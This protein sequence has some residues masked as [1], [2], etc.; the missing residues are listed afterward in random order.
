MPA[1]G[2]NM[3]KKLL[4]FMLLIFYSHGH[5][6][7][8]QN[9]ILPPFDK[10][11]YAAA[12]YKKA[13]DQI[14]K[15]KNE[16]IFIHQVTNRY[17]N[18]INEWPWDKTPKIPK[19]I[20]QIWV[21]PAPLPATFAAWQKT[22]LERHPDWDYK[23]WTD[24]DV[25]ELR[26]INQQLYNETKSYGEKANILRYE[27]LNLYGGVYID[28]DFEAIQQL[29]F[30]HHLCDFYAGFEFP[31]PNK[32]FLI[33]GNAII[34]SRAGH[35]LLTLFIHQMKNHWHY[36]WQPRRSGTFYITEIIK[37][38][39]LNTPNTTIILPANFF[40]PWSSKKM[41]WET[42]DNSYRNIN[43]PESIGFHHWD[44]TWQRK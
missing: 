25:V 17:N 12:Q 29:D 38:N 21:G 43:C 31:Q 22:W 24:A 36:D 19:I 4:V 37:K 3:N 42:R 11:M 41:P 5:Q 23:L 9:H 44:L 14:L 16:A 13:Y 18:L 26:L 39:I 2:K 30:L 20:H 33:I 8:R 34:G 10:A 28:T 32:D 40:Y 6:D 27:I 1:R 35:P 7:V 15:N